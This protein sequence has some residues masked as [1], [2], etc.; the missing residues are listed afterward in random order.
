MDEEELPPPPDE[1]EEGFPPGQE[2]DDDDSHEQEDGAEEDEGVEGRPAAPDGTSTNTTTTSKNQHH[3]MTGVEVANP[4]DLP[5]GSTV[6]PA[7]EHE[8]SHEDAARS[9]NRAAASKNTTTATAKKSAAS[10]HA[11][12]NSGGG[13]GAAPSPS[14]K[15]SSNN[16]DDESPSS[17][18]PPAKRRKK[19]ASGGA[20]STGT[21][22]GRSNAAT[23]TNMKPFNDML[24]DLLKFRAKEGHCRVPL[25]NKV[26]NSRTALG[27]WVALLRSQYHS[28]IKGEV[29]PDLTQ[30][31]LLVLESIG[32]V[33]DLQQFDSNLRWRRQFN[34]LVAYKE[35]HGHCNVPQSTHLG[36]WVKMQRE[37]Y[38]ETVLKQSGDLPRNRAKPRPTMS[39]ERM[40]LLES[41]G[42]QWKVA[43]P[44]VGW[45][46]RFEELVEY[47]NVHGDCNV[48]QAW[49]MNKAL[50]RWVM[51]QVRR[52]RAGL[53]FGIDGSFVC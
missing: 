21:S 31:R 34:D 38:R 36:R 35:A 22:Y 13:G 29:V 15:P 17:T 3:P 28:R 50:G 7:H 11:T 8:L 27:R 2:E 49:P 48:P 14:G 41:I 44:A 46:R 10:S 1:E 9:Q 52:Q 30:D 5:E 33:W 25:H 51:K 43:E 32:F 4:P 16:D 40:Q 18:P 20:S 45:D 37:N 26:S 47:R 19:N 12:S 23:T 42:F 6:A 24:F 39:A 53:L